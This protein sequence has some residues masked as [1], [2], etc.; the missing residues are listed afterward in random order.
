MVFLNPSDNNAILF[1]MG[2]VFKSLTQIFN[3]QL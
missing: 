3:T 1:S 2:L